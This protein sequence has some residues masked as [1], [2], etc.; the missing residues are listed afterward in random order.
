VFQPPPPSGLPTL[1]GRSIEN[2]RATHFPGGKAV[3]DSKGLFKAEIT[4]SGLEAIVVAGLQDATSWF[5]N[6]DFYERTF[7]YPNAG[8]KSVQAGR[9]VAANYVTMVVGKHPDPKYGIVE[10]SLCTRPVSDSLPF[11]VKSRAAG[12]FCSGRPSSYA[13]SCDSRKR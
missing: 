5:D 4:D 7:Y 10:S 1:T 3:D 6:G 2:I 13:H 12:G 11:D 8:Y 9:G